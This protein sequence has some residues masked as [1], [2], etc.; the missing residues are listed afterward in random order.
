MVA[1][2]VIV[3]T[4]KAG[5]ETAWRWESTGDGQ[6]EISETDREN[7]GTTVILHLLDVDEEKDIEDYTTDFKIRS[8]VKRYSNYIEYPIVMKTEKREYPK[9]SEGK[10]DYSAEPTVTLEDEVINSQKA[11]WQRDESDVSD[12]EYEEFYKHVGKDWQAPAKRIL[13]R[14][15][16]RTEFT[17]L[18]FIPSHRP[19]G[20]WSAD[21]EL[22]LNLYI[23]NVFIMSDYKDLIPQYL[24]FVRGVV[25]AQDLTLNISRELLQKNA[26]IKL[27]N[28]NLTRKI[29]NTF[30]DMLR[31]ERD[32]YL[33]IWDDFGIVI[34]EGLIHDHTNKDKILDVCLFE[35]TEMKNKKTTLKEYIERMPEDQD[36]I[37]YM[38]GKS[39]SL[40]ENSPHL[41]AFREKGYEVL[42]LI[43]NVDEIW[44]QYFDNYKDKPIKSVGKGEVDFGKEEKSEEV[45]KEFE[46]L[47]D[48]LKNRLSDKVKDVRLSGRLKSSPAC[49]VGEDAD[50]TPQMEHLLR[51][52]GQDIQPVKRILE[53]NPEHPVVKKMHD[54]YDADPKSE[55]VANLAE[56]IFGQAALAEGTTLDNPADFVK[57]LSQLLES[58]L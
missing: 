47:I 43:D 29:L 15:E 51:A 9:D 28:K 58:K 20:L 30:D 33:K 24:R 50:M 41:E 27:I 54:L 45:E 14:A 42:L 25:D 32:D 36:A 8:I 26:H 39:R 55:T 18:L 21:E 13:Y 56:V 34:K 38:T 35:S 37:Y 10:I 19:F 31:K 11:I 17:A 48:Y 40:I 3:I 5:E 6:F 22:G 12:E 57:N 4:R 1:K 7:P 49:L 2:K 53:L 52:A 46:T 44:T 23:K 16:G